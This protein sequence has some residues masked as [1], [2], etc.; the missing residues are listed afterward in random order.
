MKKRIFLGIVLMLVVVSL[1]ACGNKGELKILRAQVTKYQ[2][3]LFEANDQIAQKDEEIASLKK[4]SQNNETE[5]K[6]LQEEIEKLKLQNAS[7]SEQLDA[8][9]NNKTSDGQSLMDLIFPIDGKSYTGSESVIFYRDS[10]LS[11]KVGTGDEIRFISKGQEEVVTDKEKNLKVW[12]SRSE[13]G[14]LYSVD[15]PG[16]KES[17]PES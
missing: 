7:A 13:A 10:N 9:A 15:K 16:I 6:A 4:E 17:E 2:N 1:T 5:K 3:E 14:L 8:I 11:Q 12:V